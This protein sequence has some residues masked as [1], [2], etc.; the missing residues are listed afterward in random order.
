MSGNNSPPGPQPLSYKMPSTP[1]PM[2]RL[3]MVFKV[4]A[5]TAGGTGLFVLASAMFTPTMGAQR[6]TR[7][8]WEQRQLEIEQAIA[9]ADQPQP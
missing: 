1:M 6:S 9:S 2:R 7:L 4:I 8:Q 3:P 5:I